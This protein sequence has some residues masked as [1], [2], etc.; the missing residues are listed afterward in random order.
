MCRGTPRFR[1][2]R[3]PR[4]RTRPPATVGCGWRSSAPL[5]A[6]ARA[7]RHH[8]HR[9]LPLRARRPGRRGGQPVR[10]DD[11]DLARGPAPGQPARRGRERAR[12]AGRRGRPRAAASAGWTMASPPRRSR[13]RGARSTRSRRSPRR[14]ARGPT[15]ACAASATAASAAPSRRRW[16]LSSRSAPGSP[17]AP[18][19]RPA[20][21]RP[22]S[23]SSS[24][25]SSP[26]P[27]CGRSARA[28]ATS[29]WTRRAC[30]AARRCAGSP[31]PGA[32]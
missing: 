9:A 23:T 3:R 11:P 32:T 10:R 27:R 29:R 6:H 7:E 20:S 12:L 21:A 13:S 18:T 14:A 1:R 5:R 16:D 22:T 26:T 2:S 30:S 17:C 19:T 25:R 4:A 24:T 15:S 8:P 31:S 28:A